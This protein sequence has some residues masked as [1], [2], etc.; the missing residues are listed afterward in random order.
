[1]KKAIKI[2][3]ARGRILVMPNS[4]KAR[5]RD[6]IKWETGLPFFVNFGYVSP[7]NKK[8][9]SKDQPQGTARY[10]AA[11]YG[12]KKFKYFVGVYWN[13][14]MLTKDPELDMQP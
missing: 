2:K 13:G 3:V 1:M 4:C 11:L 5:H 10:D 9:F 8:L 14:K 7:L 6:Q 12:P